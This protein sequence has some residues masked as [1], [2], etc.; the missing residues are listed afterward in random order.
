MT[1]EPKD[2][3]QAKKEQETAFRQGYSDNSK[4]VRREAC[5]YEEKRGF[6]DLRRKW[7]EGWDKSEK[8]LSIRLP[9]VS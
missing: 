4:G 1:K 2:P 9:Q 8:G 7:H 5:P 6:T 3:T